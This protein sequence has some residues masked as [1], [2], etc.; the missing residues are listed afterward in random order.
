MEKAYGFFNCEAQKKEI[1]AELP[2][3]HE[4]VRS[5]S[6]LELSLFESLNLRGDEDI[7]T[8]AR[9]LYRDGMRYVLEATYL[10]Q[11]NQK[12]ADELGAIMGQIRQSTLNPSREKLIVDIVY[13]E[14][15][16]YV[17]KEE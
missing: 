17:F 1:E 6:E 2:K 14:K 16:E 7:M 12:A 3:I 8:I 11:T 10:P 15:G 13:Q 9:R 5:P 4:L